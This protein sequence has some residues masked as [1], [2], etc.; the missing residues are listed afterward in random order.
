MREAT[1]GAQRFAHLVL[2][3]PAS[4]NNPGLPAQ[5]AL[6]PV[7]WALPY[8]SVTKNKKMPTDRPKG[9]SDGGNPPAGI[10]SDNSG[11]VKLTAEANWKISIC[12]AGVYDTRFHFK[13]S[14][15]SLGHI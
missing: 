8:P 10:P 3:Q 6:S 4:L 13:H 7:G 15:A 5:V 2:A 1:A 14:L 12:T 11:L 9:Q